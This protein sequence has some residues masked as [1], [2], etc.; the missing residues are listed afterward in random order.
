MS[1][2]EWIC[3]LGWLGEM[4]E[5]CRLSDRESFQLRERLRARNREVW[6]EHSH[7]PD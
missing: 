3:D 2:S 1:M 5:A 4:E 6:K 7:T